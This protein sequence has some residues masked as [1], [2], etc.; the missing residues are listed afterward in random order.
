MI[1]GC[2]P[3]RQDCQEFRVWDG[4]GGNDVGFAFRH[5]MT[6]QIGDGLARLG[7]A[8][9]RTPRLSRGHPVLNSPGS[10]VSRWEVWETRPPRRVV[11]QQAAQR[12]Q[13]FP[14]PGEIASAAAGARD[15]T[16]SGAAISPGRRFPRARGGV[17]GNPREATGWTGPRS[18]GGRGYAKRAPNHSFQAASPPATAVGPSSP[19]R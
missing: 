7:A 2:R 4:D 10:K 16:A 5:C 9:G 1:E 17:H 19:Y 13:R 6:G 8:A 14:S 12:R 15:A 11:G 18:L 3:L